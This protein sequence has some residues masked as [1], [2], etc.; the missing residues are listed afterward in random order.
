VSHLYACELNPDSVEALR[1]NLKA[2]GVE[3]QCEVLPG[4]NAVTAVRLQ[5]LVDRVSLGKCY[6]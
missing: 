1:R 6:K 2:N 5:G 4:D 3:D